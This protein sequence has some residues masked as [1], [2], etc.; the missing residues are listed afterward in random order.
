[1][2]E[3]PIAV[4]TSISF[5]SSI[6][7]KLVNF[8]DKTI[9]TIR[10]SAYKLG[11]TRFDVAH[12]IYIVDCSTYVDHVLEI[13]SPDAYYNLVN[14]TGTDKPTTQHYYDFFTRLSNDPQH[15]WNK[16][17]NVDQL[18]PGDILVFRNKAS[19]RARAAG[20]VMIVMDK[21]VSTEVDDSFLVR[22]ADSA[23]SGHSED[24]R[25]HDSGIGIGTMIIKANP[26]TG[27]PAA[28]AWKFGSR[29]KKNVTFAM[30]RP[31]DDLET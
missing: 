8:V 24:T 15:Y 4:G 10:Y 21:P 26:K 7:H 23:S 18:E 20:H 3:E 14:S 5:V 9:D 30:A 16:V 29:W 17:K 27:Q 22:V 6:K 11:G 1:L 13:T 28:Y 2:A 19:P 12:G 31:L 25:G